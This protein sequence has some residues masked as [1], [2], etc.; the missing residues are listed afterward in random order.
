MRLVEGLVLFCCLAGAFI[1]GTWRDALMVGI[2]LMGVVGA[3][4]LGVWYERAER[5]RKVNT[6]V[7]RGIAALRQHP[8]MLEEIRRAADPTVQQNEEVGRE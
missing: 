6:L 7:E 4:W 1:C 8:E 5:E 3:F 2:Y